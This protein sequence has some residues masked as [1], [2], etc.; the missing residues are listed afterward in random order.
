MP[1][2]P[3]APPSAMPNG[4]DVA[5]QY[6]RQCQEE[7]REPVAEFVQLLAGPGQRTCSVPRRSPPLTD[8]DLAILCGYLQGNRSCEELELEGNGLAE[9][10]AAHIATVLAENPVLKCLRLGE[11]LLRDEGVLLLC[12]AMHKNTSVL[13]VRVDAHRRP[14]RAGR[15]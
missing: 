7:G 9:A 12:A 1:I 14:L 10:A 2:P 8:V 13:Q 6:A 11:N 15:G 5:E 3:G 4:H